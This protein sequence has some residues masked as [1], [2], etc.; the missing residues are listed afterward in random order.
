MHICT[1]MNVWRHFLTLCGGSYL[2]VL[3]NLM[4]QFLLFIEGT[5]QKYFSYLNHYLLGNN[6]ALQKLPVQKKSLFLNLN[7]L[8]IAMN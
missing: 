5:L 6:I 1:H 4:Q 7:A 8:D 2:Y 3:C